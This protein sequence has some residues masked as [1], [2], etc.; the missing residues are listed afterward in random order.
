MD[1]AVLKA[2]LSQQAN[3][4][5]C[6][7]ADPYFNPRSMHDNNNTHAHSSQLLAE[8]ASLRR[9]YNWSDVLLDE[10]HVAS[11]K[12]LYAMQHQ[13]TG[14]C[15]FGWEIRNALGDYFCPPKSS[16][17]DLFKIG[18]ENPGSQKAVAKHIIDIVLT[19][20]I[21]DE[22]ANREF[23]SAWAEDI[24][25]D[26]SADELL[27]QM[28][29]E[30]EVK[31]TREK[32]IWARIQQRRRNPPPASSVTLYSNAKV[33]AAATIHKPSGQDHLPLHPVLSA[34]GAEPPPLATEQR[35]EPIEESFT[36]LD[37]DVF[38]ERRVFSQ[39]LSLREHVQETEKDRVYN[40]L[41]MK[42]FSIALIAMFWISAVLDVWCVDG[43]AIMIS[44]AY[45]H[46]LGC[47]GL[48]LACAIPK[49]W[50]LDLFYVV[51]WLSV[52]LMFIYTTLRI[53]VYN[54]GNCS[55]EDWAE[56]LILLVWLFGL[57]VVLFA[58]TLLGLRK[59]TE[60]WQAQRHSVTLQKEVLG[61]SQ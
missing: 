12:K 40:T 31:F 2:A 29:V 47:W 59:R 45:A 42:M 48:M 53:L 7:T 4:S 43:W 39:Y 38:K 34:T 57:G 37:E 24:L 5:S 9:L 26:P 13:V 33:P 23:L 44:G 3:V 20:V 10:S 49:Y 41:S 46:V 11:L 50:S 55:V 18:R 21:D 14:K 58:T 22:V 6:V 27:A 60:D 52:A 19:A 15:L 35:A 32:K 56:V 28:Y 25:Q 17:D 51:G 54:F 36:T 30:M 1:V 8:P 61:K 16:D